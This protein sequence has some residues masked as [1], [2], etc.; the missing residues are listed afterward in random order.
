[1]RLFGDAVEA[2]YSV[3]VAPRTAFAERSTVEARVAA[4]EDVAGAAGDTVAAVGASVA[5][6][7]QA[8]G[9]VASG[10]VPALATKEYVAQQIAALDDLSEV[11]F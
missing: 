4:V 10:D 7:E 8:A 9:V 6:I 1:M 11:E 5:A 2:R 3:G